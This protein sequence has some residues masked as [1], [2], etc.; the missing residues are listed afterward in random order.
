M[1]HRIT[2][3]VDLGQIA[4]QKRKL[5][6]LT[7]ADLAGYCEVGPRFVRELERGKPTVRLD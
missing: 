5:D 4:A 2:S 6:G 1:P 3:A 7:Q